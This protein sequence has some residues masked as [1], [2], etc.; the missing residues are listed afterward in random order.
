[1]SPTIDVW[2]T[3]DLALMLCPEPTGSDDRIFIDQIWPLFQQHTDEID[4]RKFRWAIS[5][6]LVETIL[7]GEEYPW[8]AVEQVPWVRTSHILTQRPIETWFQDAAG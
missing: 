7:R 4:G 3:P 6:E 1:M 8:S 2:I 5:S